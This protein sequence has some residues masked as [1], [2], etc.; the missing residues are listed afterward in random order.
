MLNGPVSRSAA[1]W[2]VVDGRINS[3]VE[4]WSDVGADPA[5][6]WHAPYTKPL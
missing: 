5:P 2:T 4:Y 6:E 3:G 1:F